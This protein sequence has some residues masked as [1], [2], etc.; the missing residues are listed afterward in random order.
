MKEIKN[1]LVLTPLYPAKDLPKENTPVVHYFT[2]QW[3]KEGYNVVVIHYPYNFP[4]LVLNLVKPFLGRIKQY[5]GMAVLRTTYLKET[6]YE[7]EGVRV[8]RIPLK[9][10]KP[11]GRY[12]KKEI[13][14]GFDRAVQYLEIIGYVPDVI[15][16]HWA[17]PTFDLIPF[18]KERYGVPACYVDHLA[19]RDIVNTYKEDAE[20]LINNI[21]LI[22]YRSRYIK[23]TFEQLYGSQ[24]PSFFCYSGIP[25]E[26]LPKQT[27]KRTFDKV[28]NFVY[29]G[30]LIKRKY[31]AEI[32]PA[33]CEVFG[34]DDFT[35]RYIGRGNEE[36]EIR[37][38]ITKYQVEKK[39]E[40]CGY[41]P[42][43]DVVKNLD[44][45]DVFV[46]ISKNETF[47]LVYL[48][49]MARGCITIASWREGFDGI[50]EDGVNGFLCEAG[51]KN[52]LAR[53][54]NRIRQMAVA[55]LNQI[56][57]NA[58]VTARKLTDKNV[59]MQYLNNLQEIVNKKKP[60]Y[61]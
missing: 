29:V 43:E 37:N 35:M 26:F 52:D 61:A 58:M 40:I 11:H 31:P 16:S 9:K 24:K 4:K 22:G 2:R 7:L 51:D 59:A 25:E 19:G 27:H 32:L 20:K 54:I 1:I 57:E 13:Q 48:E 50:I 6:E 30:T 56:S 47:G 38:Q 60:Q 15:T 44:Q 45:S 49:A 18:F 17:N 39:V 42:R 34:D 53:V 55:E 14:L 41:M 21:D 12:S 28:K 46:M 3:V 5:F 8:K 10:T 36:V 23:N 33:L